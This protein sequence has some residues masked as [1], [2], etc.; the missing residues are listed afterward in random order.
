M[1]E[2]TITKLLIILFF[3]VSVI[4]IIGVV[5]NNTLLQ[6]IFKPLIIPLLIALYW[7]SVDKRNI[8][9][10]IALVFSFLGDVF[11]LDKNNLFIFGIAS[12][13]ITQIL[14]ITIIVKQ[15]KKPTNF[16]KYLYA[17]LYAN[18][19]VYL[20]GLLKPNLGELLYPVIVYGIAIAIFALVATLNY[21][22]K[23]NNK[24]LILMFGAI[25]FV[26]SDSMIALY[27]FHQ[28]QSIYPVA[29]MTTYILA[30]YFIYKFMVGKNEV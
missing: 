12:F 13:L 29:I 16:H 21:V 23:R 11:L 26:A 18:Y 27:K 20:I 9:Y 14:F 30:Q 17:F 1:K 10:I 22:S 15:M 24:T 25:L 5:I 6:M 8:W 28:P 3:T 2:D 7:F 19:V 4:E